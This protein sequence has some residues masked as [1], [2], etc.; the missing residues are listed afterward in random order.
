MRCIAI[1]VAVSAT[2]L[3]A[4]PPARAADNESPPISVGTC[5]EHG[6]GVEQP[7]G[8]PIRACCLDGIVARGCYICDNN[9]QNCVWEPA[10]SSMQGGATG[11]KVRADM[12]QSILQNKK[13]NFQQ[14][15][16]QTGGNAIINKKPAVGGVTR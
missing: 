13:L 2:L 16:P 14:T 5:I 4:G 15:T 7:E 8:S 1:I 6:G 3:L 10:F 12:L 9:W 11:P